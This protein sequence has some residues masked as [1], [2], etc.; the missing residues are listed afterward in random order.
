MSDSE[1]E[2][3]SPPVLMEDD[4]QGILRVR[5]TV[6]IPNGVGI[7]HLEQFINGLPHAKRFLVSRELMKY[8]IQH[9]SVRRD[10]LSDASLT[11]NVYEYVESKI[12]IV[13]GIVETTLEA[14]F[15]NYGYWDKRVQGLKKNAFGRYFVKALTNMDEEGRDERWSKQRSKNGVF[16]RGLK[17][18]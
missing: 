13:G 9:I 5:T 4:V 16:Y 17:L 1:E 7:S 8:I 10:E 11:D 3:A 14:V 6:E 18:K 2:P 15:T 12:D